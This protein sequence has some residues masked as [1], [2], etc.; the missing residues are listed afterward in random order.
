[1][2]TLSTAELALLERTR[3]A[4]LNVM[5][6]AG[7]GIAVSGVVVGRR[8]VVA[9]PW[10]RHKA[11]A[12]GT[13]ALVALIVAGFLVRRVLGSRARLRDPA[14]RPGRFYR[15]HVLG[16]TIGA[17]AVPL[18]FAHGYLIRPTLVAVAPYWVAALA[19][20]AINFPRAV[21][22]EGLDDG[23]GSSS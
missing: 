6:V 2:T 11:E 15:A 20:G 5:V 17:L 13:G 7:L 14:T 18:G 3:S 8:V 1:M 12:V 23:P 10:P 19:L 21:E 9:P 4:V 16:A 22:L